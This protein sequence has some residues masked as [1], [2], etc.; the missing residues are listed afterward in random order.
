MSDVVWSIDPRRDNLGNL[1]TRIRRFASDMLEC[2]GIV[3]DL[4]APPGAERVRL[5][6]EQRRHIFLILKE[7]VNNAARH[8]GCASV[9]L[10]LRLSGRQLTAGIHDNGAGFLR[11]DEDGG[12]GLG[13]M[14]ARAESL[15]GSFQVDSAPGRGTSVT[16]QVPL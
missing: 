9:S 6:P 7:A 1:V 15:G 14:R 2:R 3:F 13:N 16:F 5:T 12:R 4:E 8:A 10:S 11:T